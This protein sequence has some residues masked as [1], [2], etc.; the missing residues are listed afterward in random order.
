MLPKIHKCITRGKVPGRPIISGNGSP[1]EQISSF[2]DEH[3]KLFV[4][5]IPSYIRDTA[6]FIGKVESLR[7]LP[8]DYLLVTM[9]VTSL[10]TNIPI[11]HEGMVAVAKCLNRHKPQY[12][13]SNPRLLALL[14]LVLHCNNFEF[15]GRHYLQIGGTAMGTKVAP[16]Y[17]NI[18][19]GELE[20]T[21]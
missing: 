13:I 18:F 19:M 17:A 2:V 16:S 8:K 9:D 14:K 21:Y 15:N 20:N 6:Y 7:N 10:Y 1:T 4:P 12:M 3:I 11:N 5:L